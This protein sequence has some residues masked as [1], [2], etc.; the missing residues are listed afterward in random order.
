MPSARERGV[1]GR[2]R[3]L[4]LGV[5]FWAFALLVPRL[6]LLGADGLQTPGHLAFALLF[7]PLSALVGGVLSGS[8]GWLLFAVPTLVL[9]AVLDEPS[10]VGERIYGFPAFL[11]TAG[12]LAAYLASAAQLGAS[13]HRSSGARSRAS[14]A[15]RSGVAV[16][17]LTGALVLLL[18]GAAFDPGAR[19]AGSRE[20]SAGGAFPT[21]AAIACWSGIVWGVVLPVV[22]RHGVAWPHLGRNGRRAGESG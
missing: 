20:P 22:S 13:L 5:V 10:L 19:F 18:W 6:H 12:A 21:V 3:V 15:R 16:V 8:A 17:V 7:L 14:E 9:P 2:L 11:M 1:R 4:L